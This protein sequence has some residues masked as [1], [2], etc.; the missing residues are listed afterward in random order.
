MLRARALLALVVLAAAGASQAFGL[1]G[2]ASHAAGAPGA[3]GAA[4]H[5][6]GHAAHGPASPSSVHAHG[7]DG[8][9]P[10]HAGSGVCTCLGAC[11]GSAPTTLAAA[12][13]APFASARRVSRERIAETSIPAVRLPFLLPYP[14]APPSRG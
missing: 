5:A 6:A 9:Q 10:S 8:A 12:P 3:H 14:T 7:D 13:D 11:H 4:A 2:C 1:Q